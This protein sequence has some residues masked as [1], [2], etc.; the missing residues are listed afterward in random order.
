MLGDDFDQ[1]YSQDHTKHQNLMDGVRFAFEGKPQPISHVDTVRNPLNP[2]LHLLPG[3]Q[4]LSDFDAA[5]TFAQTSSNAITTLQNLPGA[6]SELLRLTEEHYGIEFTLVDM[7]PSLSAINQN[8]FISSHGFVLP[9]NPDPFSIM[10]I[11]TLARVLPRWVQWVKAMESAFS[12][13]AYPLPNHT[14]KF[15]GQIIQRFNIR[16]G[17]AARPYRDNIA[18]IKRAVLDT[19]IPSIQPAGMLFPIETYEEV[20]GQGDFTIAEIPDFQSLLPKAHAAGVPVF[21]LSNEQIGE[22]GP[23]LEQMASKRDSFRVL[24]ERVVQTVVRLMDHA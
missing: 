8:L 19:L 2:N 17:R 18:E 14:P 5:L 6:F 12:G 9:T 10:A 4:N 16:R 21:A 23:V 20:Y 22:T 3:H 13:S 15:V 7:N 24:F 11:Q 1:Y